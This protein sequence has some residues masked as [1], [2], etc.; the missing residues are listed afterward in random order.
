M[1]NYKAIIVISISLTVSL[2]ACKK[3]PLSTTEVLFPTD[4][5]FVRIA[6]FSP[7]TPAVMIKSNDVK[8]N[9]NFTPGF[10]GFYPST[11]NFPDYSAITPGSTLKLALPNTG[12]QNDSVVLFNSKINTEAGKFY[13]LTLA[14]TGSKRTAFTTEDKF[15]PQKDSFLSVRLIN[16]MVGSTLNFIRIDSASATDVIRDT[17]AR[18]IGYM[19]TSGFISVRTFTTRPFIRIRIT[20]NTGINLGSPQIPPQALATG[21]RRSITYYSYGFIDG[22]VAPFLP[23][24]ASHITNQ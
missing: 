16:A 13:S 10:I 9:G 22:I 4:K 2:F 6:M 5:A 15:L 20:T 1:I 11:I 14:D 21:S 24:L 8:L 12:T 19:E 17:L 23:L 7:G 18:N 3:V